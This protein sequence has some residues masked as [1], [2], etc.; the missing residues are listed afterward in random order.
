MRTITKNPRPRRPSRSP[1]NLEVGPPAMSASQALQH[2]YSLDPSSPDFLRALYGL[3][4][5]DKD[6]QYSSSLQGP[7]LTRL[8]DFLDTVRP[9]PLVFR[10]LR[11][12]PHRPSV[13][14]PSPT[15]S[16]DNVYAK[17]KS[18]AAATLPYHPRTSYPVILPELVLTRSP[19]VASPTYMK[20][21]SA[22]GKSASR[23]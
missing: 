14:F 1:W 12:R 10:P 15:T 8:V 11:N 19:G 16:S 4:R 5:L 20:G 13:L 3:I 22:I 9:L 6:E 7:E 17:C 2:L 23:R 21:L 18:S